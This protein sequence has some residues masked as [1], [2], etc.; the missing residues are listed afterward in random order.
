MK[1]FN[2]NRRK[3]NVVFLSKMIFVCLFMLVGSISVYAQNAITGTVTDAKG[4]AVIGASVLVRGTTN[5]TI[6]DIDGH[7]SLNVTDKGTLVI[8]FIGYKTEEISLG[9]KTSFKITLRED[10]EVLDEVV[11]VGYGTQ[12]KETLTGAITKVGDEAFKDKGVVN[13]PLQALQGQVAGMTVS[14]TSG[15]PGRESWSF[16]VRGESS[17]NGS[18]ALVL[19][20]GIPGSMDSMNPDDIESISILKD[21]S[22]AI[23]GARAAG[24]VVLVTTKRGRV[25]APKV[26]YK[27]NLAVKVPGLVMDYM[28]MKHYSYSFEEAFLNDG[29]IGI[30]DPYKKIFPDKVL[31]YMKSGNKSVF[32]GDE[33]FFGNYYI[34]DTG[35]IH[36][37]GL[38][39]V[40][41]N[42]VL[43][44]T[45]VSHSHSISVQ[46]GSEFNKYNVSIGYMN[47]D[48]MLKWGVDGSQRYNVRLNN[49]FKF[50][51]Y[52]SLATSL[53]FERRVTEYPNY[54]PNSIGG[55]PAGSPVS[56]IS[57]KPYAWGG[58][59]GSHWQ[60][61]L[62]GEQHKQ[63]NSFL[64]N[65]SPTVNIINGLKVTGNI[66]F[67]PY[68]SQNKWWETPIEWFYL[69][70]TAN[71]WN[72]LATKGKMGRQSRTTLYQSYQGQVDYQKRFGDHF[73]AAMVGTSYEKN[74]FTYFEATALD[75]S[76]NDIHSLNTT[77]GD[78]SMKDEVKEWAL[79]SYFARANYSYKDRYL[80]EVLGRYDGS[81]RFVKD[82]RWKP[83][84]GVSAGWRISEEK[85]MRDWGIF[86]NLKLRF[87]YG[88]TGNQNEI[89][90]YDYIALLDMKSP[91]G[92]KPD[93]PI[94]G[95]GNGAAASTIEQ[96][97]VVALDRTWEK[98]V[99]ADI[100]LDFSLLNNRLSGTI[101]WYQKKNNN[102][103]TSVTYPAIFGAIAP[104]TNSGELR[105]RGWEVTISWKDR[106]G[107]FS[108]Y[109]GFNISDDKNVLLKMENATTKNIA[110][111]NE[112]VPTTYLE[113]YA[114]N[115]YWGFEAVKLIEN[116]AELEEYKKLDPTNK[117][118]P[119]KIR[120][121]DMMYK[122]IN[123]DG[124][125]TSDDVKLLGDQ[126]KRFNYSFNFGGEFKGID[127]GA[128]FQ[129]VG[130]RTIF[131]SGNMRG[132][133]MAWFTRQ[134]DSYWGKYWSDISGTDGYQNYDLTPLNMDPNA[135]P[136]LSTNGA[137]NNYNYA[138]SDADYRKLNG[139]YLRLKNIV[140]GYTLPKN[141][142]MKA[143]IEKV[144]IYF[145]G[146]DLFEFQHI[147]DGWDPETDINPYG[148]EKGSQAYPFS[149]SFSFGLDV[150]F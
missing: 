3:G 117:I 119:A 25:Q 55:Q 137:I 80:L 6:T 62:G 17:I 115:T 45:A 34:Q 134:N 100:G 136:K 91:S 143:K 16:K 141:L 63:T 147:K 96:Q 2:H 43:W 37:Y 104:K 28:N 46:G 57:G 139:A 54:A 144:R 21:A 84:W 121:G 15:A 109:A 86:D 76:N 126:S 64:I 13:N 125:L 131:R 24:G 133:Y 99:N 27:G 107:K 101:D 105:T 53:A 29:E 113:G 70:D 39:D 114:L 40:D 102:M 82:K 30:D 12:K 146:S 140:V 72:P 123:N 51:K 87:S 108:Y 78:K 148:G 116:Q 59:Y 112:G 8:S 36:D 1:Q 94:F 52:V 90:E 106:I 97:N 19:I 142:T 11:V 14:R 149:R 26:T 42:D 110:W 93:Q 71:Q 31:S 150:T 56:T 128:T 9:S 5:G 92:S 77:P 10:A 122:D 18:N 48:S 35:D 22:A 111:Q 129:G 79:A 83:F 135:M 50:G 23:Y 130:K 38:N 85:F 49:D 73:F 75:V 145:N 127:F 88:E 120:I 95:T 20:D 103:L 47:D 98:V 81:S 74:S 4:E 68:D 124:E 67:N 132:P 32:N 69:D 138:Y 89:R 66:S 33:N 41:W 65:L 61:E 44:G 60:A 58:Q 7:F 118:I